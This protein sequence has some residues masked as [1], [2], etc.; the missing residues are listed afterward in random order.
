MVY[1]YKIKLKLF[2]KTRKEEIESKTLYKQ[3]ESNSLDIM[4]ECWTCVYGFNTCKLPHNENLS[5]FFFQIELEIIVKK[6]DFNRT[7]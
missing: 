5:I 3:D 2:N 4:E 1:G 7:Q 6:T